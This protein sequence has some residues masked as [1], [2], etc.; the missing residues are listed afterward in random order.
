M[1][2][3][4]GPVLLMHPDSKGTMLC[5][6]SNHSIS[7][8]PYLTL[9]VT[10]GNIFRPCIR[11]APTFSSPIR[12]GNNLL[13]GAFWETYIMAQDSVAKIGGKRHDD[14]TETQMPSRVR[15]WCSTEALSFWCHMISHVAIRHF[16]A[17]ERIWFCRGVIMNI[18]DEG[19]T[20][21][22]ANWQL[23]CHWNPRSPALVPS[24]VSK[25]YS[26]PPKHDRRRSAWNWP[27]EMLYVA[28]TYA[29]RWE[30]IVQRVRWQDDQNMHSGLCIQ[31]Q[32]HWICNAFL[33]Y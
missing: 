4:A 7:L 1:D 23:S 28:L 11:E 6:T 9:L 30:I 29:V 5:K 24:A 33:Q 22:G 18:W 12:S 31:G 25:T 26:C 13:I 27:V 3:Y 17:I 15:R 14:K 16:L 10:E 19:K 8:P 32:W 20:H 21:A 2:T